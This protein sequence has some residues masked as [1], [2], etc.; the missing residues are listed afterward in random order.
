MYAL[1]KNGLVEKYPYSLGMLRQ[2][3]PDTS[4]PQEPSD[5]L[6]A[7]WGV[8][9][10]VGTNKPSVDH[11]KN[12]AEG[13]PELVDGQWMQVWLV[14]DASASEVEQ[15]TSDQAEYVRNKRNELI[16]QCDWTQLNDAPINSLQRADWVDYR[17][18]LR[19]VPQQ[20]G[21]PWEVVWPTTP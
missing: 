7:S 21:F 4:F 11:T 15:R 2:N 19:D 14:T 18:A 16:S 10:V 17:Q 6:L 20:S 12:V 3:N 9:T 8:Y 1:I 5:E 13:V